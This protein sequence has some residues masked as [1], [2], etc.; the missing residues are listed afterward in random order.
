MNL[1]LGKN[2]NSGFCGNSIIKTTYRINYD[3][4]QKSKD[5][6][7]DREVLKTKNK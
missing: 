6:H 1:S 5:E 2:L 3:T 4:I 7:D